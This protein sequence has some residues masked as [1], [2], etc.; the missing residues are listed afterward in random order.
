[1][2]Q[3]LTANI[4]ST[5]SMPIRKATLDHIQAAWNLVGAASFP[6]L[7]GR[8]YDV[9]GQWALVGCTNTTPGGATYT[10]QAGLI[11]YNNVLYQVDA[12]TVVTAG[13]Q[14]PV[15]SIVTTYDATDPTEFTNAVS[16]NIHETKKI[17]FAAGTSGTGEFDYGDL[18]FLTITPQIVGA[19]GAIPY[20][21]GFDDNG[22]T[23]SLKYARNRDGLVSIYGA[24]Y[25]NGTPNTTDPIITL[26]VNCRPP[27]AVILP[28]VIRDGG[29][30]YTGL[31]TILTTG[32]VVGIPFD[33]N[34]PNGGSFAN[35]NIIAIH[36]SYYEQ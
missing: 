12:V 6:G 21:T 2:K 9:T 25:A 28:C 1:M 31:L 3:L 33:T 20:E 27:H 19:S 26:P 11:I 8:D 13:P 22:S 7:I 34:W 15:A 36:A 32:E 10:I 16:Y 30:T 23:G 4:T 29:I 17:T 24:A 18:D 5:A 14:V 35:D